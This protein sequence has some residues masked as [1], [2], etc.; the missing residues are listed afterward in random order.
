MSGNLADKIERYI[1]EMLA[2]SEESMVEIQRQ[3]VAAIFGCVPSQ[4]NYVLTTR[5]AVEHGYMVESRRGGGGYVRIVKLAIKKESD[6]WEYLSGQLGEMLSEGQ[7]R[8]VIEHL[9]EEEIL[10]PRE[11]IL[12][13]AAIQRDIL[14]GDMPQRDRLRARLIRA[15]LYSLFRQE[16]QSQNSTDRS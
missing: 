2:Q 14:Q 12:M 6:L 11:G 5:F 13:M 15:M 3:Q 7:G 1:K 16:C 4:I 9:V 10:T 8:R